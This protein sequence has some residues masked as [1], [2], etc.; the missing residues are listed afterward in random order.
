LL[1]VLNKNVA[2]PKLVGSDSTVSVA[3]SGAKRSIGAARADGRVEDSSSCDSDSSDAMDVSGAKKSQTFDAGSEP[4][5]KKHCKSTTFA[6]DTTQRGDVQIAGL[7]SL[8]Q[9]QHD[10]HVQWE[11]D[12]KKIEAA[13]VHARLGEHFPGT[14]I[15]DV[16][17]HSS[18]S[19]AAS[20]SMLADI[21]SADAHAEVASQLEAALATATA[22]RDSLGPKP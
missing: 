18:S 3:E 15:Q 8:Q 13:E 7:T 10:D 12:T 22:Y 11:Q 1:E 6:K 21:K 14:P 17:M 4:E 5:S 16:D 2:Y 20:G 19:A 9:L